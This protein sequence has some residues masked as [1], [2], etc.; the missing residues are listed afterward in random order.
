MDGGGVAAVAEQDLD[1]GSASL[2]E[3]VIPLEEE[4]TELLEND[5]ASAAA[6][7]DS[8]SKSASAPAPAPAPP[9]SQKTLPQIL[10]I[11]G[12]RALGGG[13]PGALAG[14][15]QVL[16]LM[17]LR[18][19]G[20]FQMRYGTNMQDTVATLYKQG[21]IPRFYEGVGFALIQGPLSRFG[22]TAANDGCRTLLKNF[23]YTR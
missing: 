10:A 1:I 20:N 22:S 5:A 2:D 12:K 14:L 6:A 13:I 3:R 4:A 8:A 15:L 21:G 11:A 16:S 19:V 9:S 17:W 18:T 7:G 23:E